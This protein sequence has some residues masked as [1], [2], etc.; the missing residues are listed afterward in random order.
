MSDQ[1]LLQRGAKISGDP[2]HLVSTLRNADLSSH[3]RGA[4]L[5]HGHGEP[6]QINADYSAH[7]HDSVRFPNVVDPRL[8][9]RIC[10]RDVS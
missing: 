5:A 10:R 3:L 4:Q 9:D 6:I 7:S 1:C 8:A 2:N